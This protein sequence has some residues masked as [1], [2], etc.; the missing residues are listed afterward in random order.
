MLQLFA[1]KRYQDTVTAR[2]I[3]ISI[4]FTLSRPSFSL[5]LQNKEIIGV[6]SLQKDLYTGCGLVFQNDFSTNW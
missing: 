2:D 6:L 1:I 5:Q 4:K 3:K